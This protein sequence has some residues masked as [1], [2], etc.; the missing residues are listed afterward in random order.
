MVILE[1][2]HAV[3]INSHS[4]RPHSSFPVVNALKDE[5]SCY[6]RSSPA[7]FGLERKEKKIG[8]LLD[9]SIGRKTQPGLSKG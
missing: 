2:L 1:L 3:P 8:K 5:P 7:A 6:D 9:V 4:T